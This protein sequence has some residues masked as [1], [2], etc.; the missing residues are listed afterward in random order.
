MNSARLDGKRVLLTR[1][2]DFMGPAPG[3]AFR[4]SGTDL[5]TGPMPRLLP[6]VPA[7]MLERLSCRAS[8]VDRVFDSLIG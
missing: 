2:N 7:P 6:A 3:E 5:I 1:S 4:D 8:Q